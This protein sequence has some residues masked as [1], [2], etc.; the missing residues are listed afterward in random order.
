[1]YKIP[2]SFLFAIIMV[3]NTNTF[4]QKKSQSIIYDA[5]TL[6]NAK[7][8]INA[9]LIPTAVDFDIQDPKTGNLTDHSLEARDP[10]FMTNRGMLASN[11][12]SILMRNAGLDDTASRDMVIK[13]YS[14]NPFLKDFVKINFDTVTIDTTMRSVPHFIAPSNVGSIGRDLMGNLVN[15]AADFLIKR[16]QE[17]ISISVFEKLKQFVTRYPEFDTLFPKTCDLIK[18]VEPY[19]YSKALDAFKAAIKEDL[20]N[21]VSRIPLLYDIPRYNLLNK[22]V[23]SLTFAF[24]GAALFDDVHTKS[25]FPEC[26]YNLGPRSFLQEDNNYANFL[27]VVVT[28]S[29]SLLDKKLADDERKEPDYIHKE[30]IFLVTHNDPVK[31]S[32]L[33][34][35]YLGL[36][37]QHT[38][39]W[40]FSA[41]GTTK[42]F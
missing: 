38:H 33:T 34:K 24:T 35:M 6:M 36:L 4:A 1:M 9:L 13:A 32:E 2:V 28:L 37:W 17:E 39:K 8:G 20:E 3:F 18:P 12:L 7:H 42:N 10:G 11:V 27:K 14:E 40:N 41:G 16:A 25:S 22:R 23:P 5:T 30:F 19:E 15:G 29:N 21:F 26:V 31:L